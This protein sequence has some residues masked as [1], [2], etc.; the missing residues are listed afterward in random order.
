MRRRWQ[1]SLKDVAALIEQVGGGFSPTEDVIRVG[2]HLSV[3][4]FRG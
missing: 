1:P 2:T 4:K 3:H